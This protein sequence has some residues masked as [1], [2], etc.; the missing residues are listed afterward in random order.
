MKYPLEIASVVRKQTFYIE[1][2]LSAID[3][4]QDESP[5]KIHNRFSRFVFC[6]INEEKKAVTANIPVSEM[7]SILEKSR[8]AFW[9]HLD[10]LSVPQNPAYT[11]KF[12][13]GALKGMSPA[14]VLLEKGIDTLRSQYKWLKENLNNFPNNQKLMDAIMQAVD[15]SE[16]NEL[17]AHP[18]SKINLYT[19]DIRPLINRTREDGKSFV[20]RI[21]I[22]WNLGM[23]YP[24]EIDI[25]NYY[26]PVKKMED[27][28]LNVQ[29][30][31]KVDE[32][33]SV[34]DLSSKEWLEMVHRIDS[35]IKNFETLHSEKMWKKALEIEKQNRESTNE[36][37]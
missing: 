26:A 37:V 15:L 30:K 14:E 11:T 19:A 32:I 36:N 4:S 34:M 24:V 31:E 20:Y 5:L 12:H 23:D 16:K 1:S 28:T 2:R 35:N 3:P 22:N 9:K 29:I 7:F 25:S 18:H 10:N 33:H 17:I 13:S 6:I 8:Y 21:S 27:G